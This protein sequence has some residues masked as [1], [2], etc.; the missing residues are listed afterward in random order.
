MA[1]QSKTVAE[2]KSEV[3]QASSRPYELIEYD[4]DKIFT[5][6]INPDLINSDITT[7]ERSLA[8]TVIIDKNKDN[9]LNQKMLISLNT[10]KI[11]NAKFNEII[12]TEFQDFPAAA[13]TSLLF[14]EGKLAMLESKA[15]KSSFDKSLLQAEIDS[16]K[17]EIDKY[18]EL[19]A[20]ITAPLINNIP[21]S[22][23]YGIE[24]NSDIDSGIGSM[25][26]SKN[27]KARAKFALDES[28]Y[29]T[30]GNYDVDGRLID[31]EEKSTFITQFAGNIATQELTDAEAAQYLINNPDITTYMYSYTIDAQA[32]FTEVTSNTYND[33]STLVL[34][35][36]KLYPTQASPE[37]LNNTNAFL[38]EQVQDANEPTVE[39][40]LNGEINTIISK[41]TRRAILK[42]ET[43]NIFNGSYND[44]DTGEL[45]NVATDIGNPAD[46]SYDGTTVADLKMMKQI[47]AKRRIIWNDKQFG[48]NYEDNRLITYFRSFYNSMYYGI[49]NRLINL[50]P[51][52]PFAA[53]IIALREV[54]IN[55]I[56]N[57]ENL[58]P[59]YSIEVPG[60]TYP[61]NIDQLILPADRALLGTQNISGWSETKNMIEVAKKHWKYV[62]TQKPAE[63]SFRSYLS[64]DQVQSYSNNYPDL[65]AGTAAINI[66]LK[67]H[68]NYYGLNEGRTFAAGNTI[69]R[70]WRSSSDKK[71]YI[72]LV[73][74][75]PWHVRWTSEYT[76][77]SKSSRMF[78][79]DNGILYLYDKE[80][81]VWQSYNEDAA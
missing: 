53:R 69:L 3:L 67:Q 27:R 20:T 24:L 44:Y 15:T 50:E 63:L 21:D 76:D 68:W 5:G 8:G 75:N 52:A 54:L 32:K 80:K 61:I 33:L 7:Y 58:G 78:L 36:T 38:N 26:L 51:Q 71:G 46:L 73:K 14:L 39:F 55:K 10:T 64:N 29:I 47:V 11:S 66:T 70:I 31:G 23:P 81:I 1:I 19:I 77:L 16:L 43:D 17:E 41:N 57:F 45:M 48:N 6:Q 74:T 25:I 49:N 56:R 42:A 18:K 72:E 28:F 13:D 22:I 59:V 34:N 12:D 65:A 35:I 79:D 62:V 2:L 9:L 40:T 30:L 4:A 60:G 37:S